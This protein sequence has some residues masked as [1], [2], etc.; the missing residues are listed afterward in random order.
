[1]PHRRTGTSDRCFARRQA[2][3][4]IRRERLILHFF[5]RP[6]RS[7]SANSPGSASRYG[8]V[9]EFGES[10][11]QKRLL[12]EQGITMSVSES[13][14][15]GSPTGLIAGKCD[16]VPFILLAGFSQVTQR[17]RAG[18]TTMLAISVP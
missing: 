9:G 15:H 16:G 14:R 2:V 5:A 12:P 18:N 7:S 8:N 4:P 6:A 1:M 13:A 17:I 11:S 3:E 10:P